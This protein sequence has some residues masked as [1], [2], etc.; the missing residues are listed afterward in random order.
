[1]RPLRPF[2]RALLILAAVPLLGAA[3]AEYLRESRQVTLGGRAETWQL[4]WEGKPRSVCGPEDVEMA[5]TCPCIG[6]AYG[7]VGK[8]ALVRKRGGRELERMALGPLFSD[9]PADN[10][11]GLAAMQWRPMYPRDWQDD[12]AAQRRGFLA[13][14][15]ARKGP[16]VMDLRDYDHDG[17][18][19]EFLV[20]VSAGPCGHTEYVAV[21]LSTANPR[22]HALGSAKSPTAPLVLPGAAWAALAVGGQRQV[23]R[24]P[25]GDHG[26]EEEEVL[27]LSSEKGAIG[28]RERRFACTED[29]KRGRLL[30]DTAV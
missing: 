15:G 12:A 30:S 1:M 13:E 20:Q 29:G 28:V 17:V 8:L 2:A 7:E 10:S 25:C 16:R 5:M 11:D 9:I 26:A 27:V 14:V 3:P 4:V 23:V 18:A 24:W 22:L 6:W 21:G 19:S